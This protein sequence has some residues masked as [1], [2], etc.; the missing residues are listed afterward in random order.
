MSIFS[1]IPLFN[2]FKLFIGC[3]GSLL[4]CEGFLWLWQAGATLLLRSTGSR[5]CGLQ[6]LRHMGSAAP[7][8]VGP[9]RTRDGTSVPCIAGSLSTTTPPGKPLTLHLRYLSCHRKSHT[10]PLATV[11]CWRQKQRQPAPSSNLAKY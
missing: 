4:L 2:F 1:I 10:V 6:E 3:A 9:A 11:Q 7:R 8:H 5:A